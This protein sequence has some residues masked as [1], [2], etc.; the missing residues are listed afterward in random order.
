MLY[1]SLW[2]PEE[3]VKSNS[4]AYIDEVSGTMC[5][6]DPGIIAV[7]VQGSDEN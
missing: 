2:D 3:D 1:G 4:K 7:A 6:T 5:A